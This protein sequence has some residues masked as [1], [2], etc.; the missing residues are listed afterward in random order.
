MIK[1]LEAFLFF[2]PFGG[3]NEWDREFVSRF[4]TDEQKANIQIYPQPFDGG[5]VTI[6]SDL[7]RPGK[8]THLSGATELNVKKV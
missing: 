3:N 5:G 6:Q 7:Y 2:I 4:L 8:V 1:V